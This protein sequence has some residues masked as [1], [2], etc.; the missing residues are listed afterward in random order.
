MALLHDV[1]RASGG[2]DRWRQ[3]RRFTVHMSIGGVLCAEKC[4][5]AQLKDL[6]VEG[7]TRQQ[8]LEMTGFAAP[9]KRAL[10]RPDRVALEGC[11]G[12]V[13]QE[14]RAT[15]A[16][17]Q[18]DFRTSSW[19]EL[20]LAYYCG[21]LIWNYLTVP[22]VFAD[23][24]VVTEELAPIEA[25]GKSLRRLQVRFPSRIAI[26]SLEHVFYFDS[27]ALLQRQEYPAAHEDQTRIAQMFSGHQRFSGIL[28]PT[29]CRQLK[30]GIDGGAVARP[31]LLD[32]EIFDAVFE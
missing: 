14:R 24:D 1:L 27:D 26:H 4:G 8:E 15:P 12:N 18:D 16:Q 29:L 23:G 21:S 19:D 2:L 6:V 17:F 22:F 25:G 10:Y 13:L 32:L 28:L 9:D 11:D 3:L 30:V 20:Q 31:F 7:C 5:G